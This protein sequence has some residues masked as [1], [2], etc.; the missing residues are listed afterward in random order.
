VEHYGRIRRQ[1]LLL[2]VLFIVQ[3]VLYSVIGWHRNVVVPLFILAILCAV[4][5][6]IMDRRR[7]RPGR[8]DPAG[9]GGFSAR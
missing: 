6:L 7:P 9:R 4:V 1:L 2:A 5:V 3:G 8:S